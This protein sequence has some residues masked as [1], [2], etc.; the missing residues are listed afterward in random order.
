ML[1]RYLKKKA[2]IS[3]NAIFINN[4]EL[5]KLV[6]DFNENNKKYYLDL[7]QEY[8][9]TSIEQLSIGSPIGDS[10]TYKKSEVDQDGIFL[11]DSY[12]LQYAIVISE[13]RDTIYNK[14][15]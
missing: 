8:L 12:V 6:N 13:I 11:I 4:S 10:Y 5:N 9:T 1:F 7:E 2:N 3:E 15:Y 14:V